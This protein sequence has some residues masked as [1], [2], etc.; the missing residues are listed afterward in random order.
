MANIELRLGKDVLVVQ[1]PMGTQLM[2]QGL[3]GDFPLPSLNITE[4]EIV[5]DLHKLYRAAGA[6]CAVT[7]TFM[8]TSSQLA[9]SGLASSTALINR[10]GV[11]LA[12]EAGFPHVLASVGPCGVAVE[13]GSGEAML[14][15]REAA[16]NDEPTAT[17]RAD[18]QGAPAVAPEW[19]DGYA[20]AVE[21]YAEQMAALASEAPDALLLE[22]F[23]SIDDALAAVEAA[24]RT[25][26]L[27]ILVCMSFVDAEDA[28]SDEQ[29]SP[30]EAAKL[31]ARAGVAAVGCNC[32]GIDE[33]LTAI[34][35]MRAACDLPLIARPSAGAPHTL[36]NGSLRWPC[37]P[38]DFSAGALRLLRAGATVLGSCCGATASCTG[39]I[40]A[41]VGGVEF[42]E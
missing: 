11:Q 17:E 24:R 35:Q 4:P 6:D 12:R 33:T 41:T 23:T 29:L 27:P 3:D 19:P 14:A 37:G 30:A 8:A 1:G 38:D 2:A 40:Y 21:Q 31:L 16:Q 7:N 15:A 5:E 34:E 9:K 18:G 26:D 32:M 42:P 13:R 39:A 22:T 28:P 25:C 10:Q 20:V 36:P